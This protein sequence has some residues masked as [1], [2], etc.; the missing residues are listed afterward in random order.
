MEVLQSEL[1]NQLSQNERL[2]AD[3]IPQIARHITNVFQ[4]KLNPHLKN[5]TEGF[6]SA[7]Q[8]QNFFKQAKENEGLFMLHMPAIKE[9]KPSEES[10]SVSKEKP[11]VDNSS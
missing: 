3:M 11:V 9:I 5:I 10:K 8:I 6:L 1:V 2:P 7:F 4:Q